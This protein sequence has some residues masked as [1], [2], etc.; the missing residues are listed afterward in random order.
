MNCETSI[1]PGGFT[2]SVSGERTRRVHWTALDAL[3]VV[4]DEGLADASFASPARPLLV[5]VG[6]TP[7]SVVVEPQRDPTPGAHQM[8][9]SMIP[10]GA[11]ELTMRCVEDLACQLDVYLS[12][13][14]HPGDAMPMWSF[15]N[16]MAGE[17]LVAPLVSRDPWMRLFFK[18]GQN[19]KVS[20]A[21]DQVQI[22]HIPT[23]AHYEAVSHLVKS[24]HPLCEK[25]GRA[26]LKFLTDAP[27]HYAYFSLSFQVA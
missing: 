7:H 18:K 16:G 24:E 20:I 15:K 2:L 5:M 12:R 22:M 17:T 6:I 27:L 9:C 3:G 1:V 25:S 26:M 10:A 14:G 19:R 13:T 4:L 11:C 8:T 23:G 21:V